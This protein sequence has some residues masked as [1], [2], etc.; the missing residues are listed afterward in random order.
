MSLS[1]IKGIIFDLGYTLIEYKSNDWPPIIQAC[2]KKAHDELIGMKI[3][4]PDFELF[5]SRL[6]AIKE[7]Y[8]RAAYEEMYGWNINDAIK[9]VLVE[10]GIN[11]AETIA[12]CYL[13][14]FYAAGRERMQIAPKTVETLKYLKD[15]GYITGVISNTIY[16]AELHEIDLNIFGL[17]P[18]LDFRIYSS[19]FG[20]R[21]PH[22]KIFAE[23]VRQTGLSPEE[24]VYIGDRYEMDALGAQECGLK[25]VIKYCEKEEY[26][27]TIS[28]DIPVINSISGIPEILGHNMEIKS[29]I[30]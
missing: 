25:P 2:N 28:D 12:A 14:E 23:G 10:F 9:T 30:P 17:K 27:A 24:V 13:N 26:P 29:T 15:R 8:R 16:P 6:E 7:E 4:L 21:K 19:E 18:Y 20:F 3:T 22:P 11:E 1:G 5:E